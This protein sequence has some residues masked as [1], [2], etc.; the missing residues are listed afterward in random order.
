MNKENFDME[1]FHNLSKVMQISKPIDGWIPPDTAELDHLY[2]VLGKVQKRLHHL[3][4]SVLLNAEKENGRIRR[5]LISRK[6]VVEKAYK[7][8][9]IAGRKN[10]S[11]L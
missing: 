5:L 10:R 7:D 2:S 9:F 6:K 4:I 8:G 11:Y 3:K 1:K